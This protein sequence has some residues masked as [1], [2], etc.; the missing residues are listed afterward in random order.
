M[1]FDAIFQQNYLLC[2]IP[3]VP[4][5]LPYTWAGGRI[6]RRRLSV[7]SAQPIRLWLDPRPVSTSAHQPLPCHL[8]LLLFAFAFFCSHNAHT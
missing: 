2:D 4:S 1:Q 7:T 8:F 6:R 3:I 5:P